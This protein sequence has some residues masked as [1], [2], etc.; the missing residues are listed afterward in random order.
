MKFE[1]LTIDNIH[2]FLPQL[3]VI[4]L[5][6]SLPI[7]WGVSEFTCYLEEKWAL[8]SVVLAE[9]LVVGYAMISKKTPFCA[10]IHRFMVRKQLQSRGVGKE[11]MAF[12]KSA[13][14]EK[15]DFL[16]LNVGLENIRAKKFYIQ[17]GFKDITANE[18]GSLMLSIL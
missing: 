8:S 15:Y 17:N 18:A 5:E 14:S 9:N 3:I 4:E 16:T 7:I 12:L 11:F 10:H 2:H 13:M 1:K 6:H